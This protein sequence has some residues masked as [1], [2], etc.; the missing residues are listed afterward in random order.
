MKVYWLNDS[1]SCFKATH[2]NT[3]PHSFYHFC[4]LRFTTASCNLIKMNNNNDNNNNI[5]EKYC[6][7][8]GRYPNSGIGIGSELKKV[9]WC[10]SSW[11][12][13]EQSKVQRWVLRT[14][15]WVEGQPSNRTVT[16]STRSRQRPWSRSRQRLG[17]TLWMSLSCPAR[18]L[19][20]TQSNISGETWQWLSTDGPHSQNNPQNPGVQ[21]LSHH[22]Q[23]NSR[24]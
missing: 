18:A 1:A 23:E 5:Q 14:S 12:K 11:G 15:D 24:L 7:G 6:T 17:T 10:I 2:H 9:V 3:H 13:A 4:A 21:S 20:R 19:T 22:T 16:V 8:I